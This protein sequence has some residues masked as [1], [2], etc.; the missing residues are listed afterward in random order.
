MI[1]AFF[2]IMRLINQFDHTW[3]QFNYILNIIF[4]LYAI[5]NITFLITSFILL[6]KW[7]FDINSLKYIQ[8]YFII[9]LCIS[10]LPSFWMV[11]CDHGEPILCI[12]GK[13]AG[14]TIIYC[15]I[16]CIIWIIIWAMTK[17]LNK[18]KSRNKKQK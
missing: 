11:G 17:P 12:V 6:I 8:E 3:T 9:W 4:I 14:I 5:W 10:I 13:I 15:I 1:I 7:L 16:Y 18:S 2:I